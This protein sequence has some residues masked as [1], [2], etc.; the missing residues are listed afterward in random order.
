MKDPG[1]Q[2]RGVCLCM[3]LLGSSFPETIAAGMRQMAGETQKQQHE[4]TEHIKDHAWGHQESRARASGYHCRSGSA[5][6]QRYKP[7]SGAE[8]RSSRLLAAQLHPPPFLGVEPEEGGPF[9]RRGKKK[10]TTS[11]G[12]PNQWPA[13]VLCSYQA[14]APSLPQLALQKME[15]TAN[16]GPILQRDPP[17]SLLT[18]PACLPNTFPAGQVENS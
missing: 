15:P 17:H 3:E 4:T 7:E 8:S 9:L 14:S 10:P 6:A 16:N 13:L 5:H 2:E 1:R 11:S 12:L 18:T